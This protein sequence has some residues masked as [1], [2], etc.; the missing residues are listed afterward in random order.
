MSTCYKRKLPAYFTLIICFVQQFVALTAYAGQPA[1]PH[2]DMD[3]EILYHNANSN[4]GTTFYNDTMAGGVDI[5]SSAGGTINYNTYDQE[6]GIWNADGS[7][8]A[9][10]EVFD[11]TTKTFVPGANENVF[12]ASEEASELPTLNGYGTNQVGLNNATA[13]AQEAE[14]A[15]PDE[16]IQLGAGDTLTVPQGGQSGIYN[17][18][19]SEAHPNLY[20]DPM[21]DYTKQTMSD[22]GVEGMYADCGLETT[23][24]ET[25]ITK[26][27]EVL[28]SCSEYGMTPDCTVNRV[29][30]RVDKIMSCEPGVIQAQHISQ[31][32]YRNRV[33]S[34]SSPVNKGL[35]PKSLFVYSRCGSALGTGNRF[36]FVRREW[37][38]DNTREETLIIPPDDDPSWKFVP[39]AEPFWSGCVTDNEPCQGYWNQIVYRNHSC[40]Q[41]NDPQYSPWDC[42]IDL[43]IVEVTPELDPMG[44]PIED[45]D[46][47]YTYNQIN[48]DADIRFPT[49]LPTNGIPYEDTQWGYTAECSTGGNKTE[50][51]TRYRTPDYADSRYMADYVHM[52]YEAMHIL[53]TVIE[54]FTDFPPGCSTST[55]CSAE[56]DE[57]Y[58]PFTKDTPDQISSDAIWECTAANNDEVVTSVRIDPKD[59]DLT[60]IY[61]PTRIEGPDKLFPGDDHLEEV[62]W[63]ATARK[64]VCG[65]ISELEPI[66]QDFNRWKDSF[67]GG[68]D[69]LRD[70]PECSYIK[71]ES[72]FTD[73]LDN[74]LAR[75]LTYDCGYDYDVIGT[76]STTEQICDSELR[77]L[78]NEC[79]KPEQESNTDFANAVA[80]TSIAGYGK[81]DMECDGP[82]DC[83]IFSGKQLGCNKYFFGEVDCC[84]DAPA[85][86]YDVLWASQN[87]TMALETQFDLS[88]KMMEHVASPAGDFV[89]GQWNSIWDNSLAQEAAQDIINFGE[90]YYDSMVSFIESGYEEASSALVDLAKPVVEFFEGPASTVAECSVE[91]LAGE[92]FSTGFVDTVAQQMATQIG[93][94]MESLFGPELAQFFFEPVTEAVVDEVGNAVVDEAGEAVT[95][96]VVEDGAT[97]FT[98]NMGAGLAN[99]LSIVGWAYMA[100]SV[101]NLAVGIAFQCDETDTDYLQK[102]EGRS[103]SK[104]NNDLIV[105]KRKH[106]KDIDK[107]NTSCCFETPLARILQEQVRMQQPILDRLQARTS[108]PL[109]LFVPTISPEQQVLIDMGFMDQ[110]RPYPFGN[111]HEGGMSCDGLSPEDLSLVDWDLVDL[112]EWIEILTLAGNIPDGAEDM[113]SQFAIEKITSSTFFT[114]EEMDQ[115]YGTNEEQL[116][117]A[118]EKL[119]TDQEQQVT[120]ESDIQRYTDAIS[121]T[122]SKIMI[123]QAKDAPDQNTLDELEE[124]LATLNELL[125]QKEADLELLIAR[126]EQQEEFIANFDWN[127]EVVVEN[128]TANERLDERYGPVGDKEEL[129]NGLVED[130]WN[131]DYTF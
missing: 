21:W 80:Q 125:T 20:N 29:V 82:D 30:D 19:T 86:R 114:Q 32:Y 25:P 49:S 94:Y 34:A 87:L 98:G 78:G 23:T 123:E 115:Q 13:D 11:P 14:A 7:W 122:E 44:V 57:S 16:I 84:E 76:T 75:E 69:E 96:T 36:D 109:S 28:K 119:I 59:S 93:G 73:S 12:D 107:M 129:R 35:K 128:T 67:E 100:Y 77:C 81:F 3:A 22:I 90:P 61:L 18:A 55:S 79:L 40:V 117:K 26:H 97:Q 89:A 8:N 101:Y 43:D 95:E 124:L 15:L 130:V 74:V 105:T 131:G 72:L 64:Y 39:G 9:G 126:I 62:C 4:E 51:C 17:R 118:E 102:W 54:H 53:F 66:V 10:S 104:P 70:N 47:N 68:C 127:K 46:G 121:V 108:T 106:G 42:K 45:I 65:D 6:T 60:G 58:D 116:A 41:M 110:P 92:T 113:A 91:S 71:S 1:Y 31:H 56:E 83:F 120:V 27:E 88:G 103:C 52:D 50:P 48:W 37:N 85:M 63:E 33:H 2:T 112:E 111:P 5:R 99:A 38:W 24:I